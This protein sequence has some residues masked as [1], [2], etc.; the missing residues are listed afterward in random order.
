LVFLALLA[1]RPLLRPSTTL[2]NYIG[3][4]AWWSGWCCSPASAASPASARRPSWASAPTPPRCSPPAGPAGLA[5]WA[6]A[7][8]WLTLLA[9][10]VLTAVVAVL[11]GSLTLKLSGHFLPLGTI[12]WGISLY[13]LFGNMEFLGGHTACPAS[14]RSPVRLELDAGGQ[15]YYLIWAFVLAAVFT[16]R[17]L[18]D[19]REGRAI[20]ALK[21]GMV[22]AEAMGVDTSR[23]RMVI[24]VI[25]ALH[26][27]ASGWL[28]AHLQRFVNP[29]P[30]G[31]TSASSTSSWRWSAAPAT[32]GARWWAP[33]SSPCSSSGCRTSCPGCSA[34]RQLRGDRL[35]VMMV[36]VLQRARDGLWPA[37]GWCR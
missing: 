23:S 30:S 26:A 8:P 17:N 15:I 34:R 33:G 11:L 12:A 18:L 10:L 4:S 2:L 5:A 13:F 37:P 36:L 3:L 21:G 32:C 27:C 7:S 31:C 20:R 9:G 1:C 35:R 22:M 28:Y 25:A 29:R 14:R 19:S 24:F 16:T 6:G